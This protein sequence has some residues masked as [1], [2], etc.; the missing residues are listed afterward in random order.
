MRETPCAYKTFFVERAFLSL[1]RIQFNCRVGSVFISDH[2]EY[3][4]GGSGGGTASNLPS[5]AS[6]RQSHLLLALPVAP[7]CT[8]SLVFPRRTDMWQP[9]ASKYLPRSQTFSVPKTIFFFSFPTPL[10]MLFF[11]LLFLLYI[12]VYEKVFFCLSLFSS[13]TLSIS[14]ADDNT[15]VIASTYHTHISRLKVEPGGD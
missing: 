10:S 13:R 4:T 8:H 5:D 9:L 12:Y 3:L 14:L 6:N 15:V 1:L 7:C 2:R 11:L